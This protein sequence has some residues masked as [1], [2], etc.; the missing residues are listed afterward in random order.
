MGMAF[1]L[2]LE[3]VGFKL[4]VPIGA[5]VVFPRSEP[6]SELVLLLLLSSADLSLSSSALFASLDVFSL[7]CFREF[8]VDFGVGLVGSAGLVG[9]V[10]VIVR[11]L[12]S[13]HLL[14]LC[15]HFCSLLL[16]RSSVLTSSSLSYSGRHLP[17]TNLRPSSELG[18]SRFPHILHC[19]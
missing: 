8:F 19:K 10:A 11:R 18:P 5:A 13:S 3:K 14:S 15:A 6:I 7:A 12:V 9:H 1:L 4:L 2:G 16:A 17:H